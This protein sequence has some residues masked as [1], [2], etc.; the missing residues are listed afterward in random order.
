MQKARQLRSRFV[1]RYWF[2]FLERAGEGV[3]QAPHRSRL[4]LL[5]HGL[6]VQLVHTPRQVLGKTQFVLDERLVDQQLCRSRRQLHRLPFL[7]LLL[8]RPEVPLHPVDADGQ[9]VFQREV[10]G[11]LREHGSVRACDDLS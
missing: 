5:M 7:D 8:Q 6:K 4:E 10:L 1:L 2:Q 9:A 11:M 3:R